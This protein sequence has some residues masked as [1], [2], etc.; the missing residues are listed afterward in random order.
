M[1]NSL[2]FTWNITFWVKAV[3]RNYEVMY[4]QLLMNGEIGNSK[5][6]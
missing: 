4:S 1:P 2:I 6:S 5:Q 3:I